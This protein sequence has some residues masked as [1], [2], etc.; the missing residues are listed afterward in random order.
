MLPILAFVALFVR[1]TLVE[2][3]MLLKELEGY[4]EYAGQVRWRL[5]AGVF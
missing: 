1:R 2:D 3:R 5:V 4:A